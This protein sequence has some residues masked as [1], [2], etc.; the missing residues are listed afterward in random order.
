MA[1]LGLTDWLRLDRTDELEVLGEF[2]TS[3]LLRHG[4]LWPFNAHFHSPLLHRARGG[5]LLTGIGGDEALSSSRWARSFAVLSG[6]ERAATARPAARGPTRC[7]EVNSARGHGSPRSGALP[8]A[9]ASGRPRGHAGLGRGPG[10]RA[11]GAAHAPSAPPDPP[12]PRRWALPASSGSLR[13]RAPRSPTRSSTPVS[14][15]RLPP[16]AALV[17]GLTAPPPCAR[18]STASCRLELVSRSSKARFEGAFWGTRSRSFA[19]T[20]T[21]EVADPEVVDPRALRRV[22]SAGRAGRAHVSPDAGGV[23]REPTCG[24]DYTFG[25]YRTW[26]RAPTLRGMSPP[27]LEKAA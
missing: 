1:H 23:A 4:L 5:S 9:P 18:S 26:G 6:A 14:S 24:R 13:M 11:R 21:G 22:W 10:V 7:A 25:Q 19:R 16:R 3:A 27:E 2:A 17:A 20:W 15:P 8:V 12:L